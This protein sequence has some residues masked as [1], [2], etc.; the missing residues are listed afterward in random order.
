MKRTTIAMVFLVLIL[1]VG[2]SPGLTTGADS[3]AADPFAA[4]PKTSDPALTWPWA[5]W[6]VYYDALEHDTL[7][8]AN[9]GDWLTRWT[10][11]ADMEGEC[12]TRLAILKS[13]NTADEAAEKRHDEF[14][15]KIQTPSEERNQKLRN[16]LLASKLSPA[17]FAL[18]LKKMRVQADIFREANLPLLVDEQKLS[19]EYMKIRGAQTVSWDGKEITESQ[20][21]AVYQKTDRGVR[22][23]AWRLSSARWLQDRAAIGKLWS[24]LLAL[25]LKIAA[26][27]GFADYRS[28]RWQDFQRFDYT[29]DEV[30]R[31]HEVIRK[32]VVPAAVRI[33]ERH[34]RQLGIDQTR[35][36]DIDVDPT[37]KPPLKPFA[38]VDEL[39]EKTQAVF[40]AIDPELGARFATMRREKTLD[41]DNRK[42]KEPGGF[43]ADLPVRGL[44][45]I[46]MNAIGVHDDVQTL[47][48]ESGHSFHFF[49]ASR[50]PWFQQRAVPTEFAEVASMSMEL[51]AGRMLDRQPNAFYSPADAARARISVLE[52]VLQFWPYMSVVDLFQHWVYEHPD[53]AAEP[54]NCDREWARLWDIYM[55]GVD[56]SGLG[57]AKETGW[58]RKLHIHTIP[59]Y[60]IEYGMAELGA[61][62]VFGRA[63]KDPKQAL[64][65][66]RHALSLGGTA[67]LPELFAAAGGKFSLDEKTMG[68]AVALLEN[69]ILELERRK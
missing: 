31:F 16:K 14:L 54:K 67:T 6:A 8:A 9:V 17:G 37:G 59:F 52:G 50:L 45:F 35:P 57:D 29:P 36:W 46:F 40:N 48:H 43:Q 61:V 15:E 60:Y 5:T 32:V 10:R 3:A 47:F 64:A 24:K 38:T 68:D 22:E 62:Q 20:L 28:F 21:T 44:P 69:T 27:A 41:L 13:A 33:Y 30:K 55:Q 34:R 65:D 63:L 26:N 7:T 56:W 25:R 42:N 12:E 53:A 49:E 1:T 11:I 4:F 58:Q 18:P 66:Y 19:D 39:V 2:V 23:K 51:M